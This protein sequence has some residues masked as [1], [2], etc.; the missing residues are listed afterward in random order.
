MTVLFHM[1]S[2]SVSRFRF[3]RSFLASVAHCGSHDNPSNLVFGCC[4]VRG[5]ATGSSLLT[6]S[7]QGSCLTKP[8]AW[9]L[10]VPWAV[11]SCWV[12]RPRRLRNEPVVRGPIRLVG[13]VDAWGRVE[14]VLWGQGEGVYVCVRGSLQEEIWDMLKH[15]Q[16]VRAQEPW[17]L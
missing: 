9:S 1:H 16:H 7:P 3:S 17:R 4:L 10:D 5:P 15:A 2:R 6:P 11:L 8:P 12:Q 14:A 13:A